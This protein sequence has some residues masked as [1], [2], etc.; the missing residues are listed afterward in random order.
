MAITSDYTILSELTL[1]LLAG[2]AKYVDFSGIASISTISIHFRDAGGSC[3]VRS[4]QESND[5]LAL[6]DTAH[7]T[8]LWED[9]KI[10]GVTTPSVTADVPSQR[11]QS[12]SIL[13]LEN[14]STTESIKFS[15][16]SNR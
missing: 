2:E 9:I 16:R 15:L 13:Y 1:V 6:A 4:A 10:N 14:T 12:P 3:K 5:Y 7:N 8:V 11:F